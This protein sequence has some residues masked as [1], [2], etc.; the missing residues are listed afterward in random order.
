V[1][2][3]GSVHMIVGVDFCW[4]RAI[5]LI[6]ARDSRHSMAASAWKCNCRVSRKLHVSGLATP[7]HKVVRS[8]TNPLLLGKCYSCTQTSKMLAL[9]THLSFVHSSIIVRLRLTLP[10]IIVVLPIFFGSPIFSLTDLACMGMTVLSIM[11][12]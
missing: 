3:V 7:R 5:D 11:E 6:V 4:N 1:S 12:L 10:T 2:S 8:S 9:K